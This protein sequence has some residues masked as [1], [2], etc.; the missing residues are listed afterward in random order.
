LSEPAASEP[1]AR[2]RGPD[3][4][5]WAV[6]AAVAASALAW[7][8]VTSPDPKPPADAGP[9]AAAS[10]VPSA[11]DPPPPAAPPEKA[12]AG[13]VGPE[14]GTPTSISQA[15]SPASPGAP[16]PSPEASAPEPATVD[17]ADRGTSTPPR[18]APAS[19]SQD[20][21]A[22]VDRA[23]G[24]TADPAVGDAPAAEGGG[25]DV[26][27]SAEPAVVDVASEPATPGRSAGEA[28]AAGGPAAP[29]SVEMGEVP[30]VLIERAEPDYPPLA[31]QRRREATVVVSAFVSATGAVERT[32]VQHSSALGLG[33]E[34]AAVDAARR[35]RFEPGRR[36]GE[37]AGFWQELSFEFTLR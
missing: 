5:L 10:P 30:P 22:D 35:C 11:A 24:S 9:V 15:P 8:L 29:V 14:P 4:R 36:G 20:H 17:L 16:A 37:P 27:A 19:G 3:R 6:P 31:R 18:G 33:F 2:R 28:V 12:E 1:A 13:P 26:G 32:L 23:S 25:V 21:S 34:A 7:L